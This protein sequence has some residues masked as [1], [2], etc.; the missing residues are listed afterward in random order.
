MA[1][2]MAPGWGVLCDQ[3]VDSALGVV[4]LVSRP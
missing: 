1:L 2:T 4:A 3:V